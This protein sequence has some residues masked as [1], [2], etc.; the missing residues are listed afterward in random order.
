VLAV[1]LQ[2]ARREMALAHGV[3]ADAR[4]SVIGYGSLGGEELGFG[5]DL[6][7]VFLYAAAGDAHSDGARPLEA[8][9]WF[10]RLAQKIVSL[11]GT[12]TAAGRLY[13]IDVRLRPD[14]AKGLLVS[15]VASFAD[16]QRERA[17]TWEHQALVR[18]RGVAGDVV[19][20]DAFEQV[21]NATL[22]CPR[23]VVALRDDVRSMR[24]KMRAELDRSDAH[25]FDLKQGE[26]GLVDLEFLLQYLV[27]RGAHAQPG[28]LVARDTPGLLDAAC[29]GGALDATTC[30]DLRVAHATLLD[31]GLR[32]TLDRRPRI[33]VE[34]DAIAAARAAI[35]EATG[36]A[37]LTFSG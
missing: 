35:R 19:L 16:Y 33:V 7:V 31:A 5:S 17:W 36:S 1:V 32:C 13:D 3:I 25:R 11:L 14:G 6:D 21:R 8:A 24:A 30:T 22:A 37:G 9:R 28:L 23:D 20:H 15:T 10:A 27:L 34:T 26:A 18:A 12:V 29:V 2:L 4:F